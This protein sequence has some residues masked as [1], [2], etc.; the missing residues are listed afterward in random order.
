[1]LGK[2]TTVYLG[3]RGNEFILNGRHAD[4]NAEEVYGKLTTPIFGRGVIYDCSNERFMDQKRVCLL[5]Y[6]YLEFV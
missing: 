6:H 3:P 5:C 1:M 2:P 4:L